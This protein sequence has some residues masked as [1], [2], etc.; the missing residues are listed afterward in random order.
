MTTNLSTEVRPGT[1][2]IDLTRSTCR[3][4]ATHAFG[5]K[6]V[7]ATLALR[8]GTVTVAADPAG[9]SASAE[10]DAGTFHSD[11]PRRDKDIT[12]KRFLDAAGHPV[13]AFRSTGCA[14]TAAGWQLTGV[15]RVR[16]QDS[17]VTLRVD[18]ARPVGDGY[19]FTAH[20]VL[21]RVT[22]GVRAG[23]GIIA[24]PIRIELDVTAAR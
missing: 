9:S 16:G 7:A 17:E 5:L 6:P 12:G 3:M 20:G 2:T 8:G 19:R 18:S 15:L 10:I 11:D 21:D 23:R 4:H 1:Y 13:I 14:R 22:A 24:R